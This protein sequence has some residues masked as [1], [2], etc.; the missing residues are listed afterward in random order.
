MRVAIVSHYFA[1]HTGG[2][3]TVVRAH[4]QWLKQQG[5]EVVVVTSRLEGDSSVELHDGVEVRRVRALNTLEKRLGV[6]VPVVGRTFERVIEEFDPELVIAHGHAYITSWRASRAAKRLG[7]P[8]IVVQHNPFVE[9]PMPL[10]TIEHAVDATLGRSVLEEAD[11]VVCVSRHVALY[12]HSIAPG[13]GTVVVHNGV[14]VSRFEP[15]QTGSAAA[16]TGQR[17]LRVGTLRRLV[18]RQGVD[19][20]IEA[21]RTAQLGEIAELVIGGSGAERERLEELARGDES[22]TFLGRVDDDR[23]V[24]FYQSCDVFVL[25]TTSGEGFGLVAAEAL[26]CGVPVVATDEGGAREVVRDGVDGVHVRAKDPESIALGIRRL[27][28]DNEER[29]RMA[30]AA[31]SRT[32]SWEERCGELFDVLRYVKD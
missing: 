21:W 29:L 4:A 25:P 9:Y 3:E 17:V 22:V 28:N 8:F 10:E 24:E 30:E 12:V 20:L 2:V 31:R 14:D 32:L 6:P 23:L 11:V 5:C 19:V 18:P 26:A 1:P 27:L 15:A 7:V 16:K 13:A